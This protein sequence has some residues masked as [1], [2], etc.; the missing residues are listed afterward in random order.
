[1]EDVDVVPYMCECGVVI[2]EGVVEGDGVIC[3][4]NLLMG[5]DG[6][7]VGGDL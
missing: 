5:Q 2:D 3:Q 4:H 7:I 6:V 1:M